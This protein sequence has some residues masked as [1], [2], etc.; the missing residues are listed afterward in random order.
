MYI[1]IA[2]AG[3]AV[4]KGKAFVQCNNKLSINRSILIE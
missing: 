1:Q 2:L 4:Q 3:S